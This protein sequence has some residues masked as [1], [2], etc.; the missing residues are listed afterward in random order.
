MLLFA[1]T[2]AVQ[3]PQG[4][5]SMAP[6]GIAERAAHGVVSTGAAVPPV[7]QIALAD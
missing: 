3:A 1:A 7:T 4:G 2:L 6:F 5:L